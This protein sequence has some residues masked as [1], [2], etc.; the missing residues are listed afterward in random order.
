MSDSNPEPTAPRSRHQPDYE[1]P[2]YHDEEPDVPADDTAA[3]RLSAK[4]KPGRMPRP[5]S[6]FEED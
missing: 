3:P 4:K 2:H 5:R 1:D 6:R